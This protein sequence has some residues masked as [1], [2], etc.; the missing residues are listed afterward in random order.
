ML[1]RGYTAIRGIIFIATIRDDSHPEGLGIKVLRSVPSGDPGEY[2]KYLRDT[3]EWLNGLLDDFHKNGDSNKGKHENSES[4]WFVVGHAPPDDPTIHYTYTI[5]LDYEVFCVDSYPMFS[6]VNLPPDDVFVKSIACSPYG[7][8]SV[9]P[10][11][12]E[13]Y[14]YDWSSPPPSVKSAILDRYKSADPKIQGV[15]QMLGIPETLSEVEMARKG[16]YQTLVGSLLALKTVSKMLY[17]LEKIED[18]SQY[19][20]D[21]FYEHFAR[22]LLGIT[23]RPMFFLGDG[24]SGYL[25]S[26]RKK[27]YSNAK[28][29][30]VK[31]RNI[32]PNADVWVIEEEVARKNGED[33]PD[34]ISFFPEPG[35]PASKP[36]WLRPG[37][38]VQLATH[39]TDEANLQAGVVSI[40]EEILGNPVAKTHPG[41]Y[42]GV[43]CSFFHCVI[44]A[45]DTTAGSSSELAHTPAL[46]LLPSL[47]ET[48]LE[49]VGLT[50]LSRL[51]CY[52]GLVIPLLRSSGPTTPPTRTQASNGA[53]TSTGFDLPLDAWA[54][55]SGYTHD[56][57]TLVHLSHVSR[58]CREAANMALRWPRVNR[59][60]VI[61]DASEDLAKKLKA[62]PGPKRRYPF[63]TFGVEEEEEEEPTEKPCFGYFMVESYPEDEESAVSKRYLMKLKGVNPLGWEDEFCDVKE[64]RAGRSDLTADLEGIGGADIWRLAEPT[65]DLSLYWGVKEIK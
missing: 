63:V 44:V 8:R 47:S 39:L 23:L 61:G 58:T 26:Y 9:D 40:Q 51:G 4:D 20:Q 42:F 34:R 50:A 46:Q 10:D 11:T 32:K 6:L 14:R 24:Q 27:R 5:D 60:K 35:R 37:L 28:G 64:G 7:H 18:S 52:V 65:L 1:R 13:E 57:K 25:D 22:I 3:R 54:L 55:I 19:H 31:S 56:V 49:T 33:A 16:V 12:P 48:S 38:C 43:L 62:T 29:R 45:V 21:S 30:Y 2:A 15:H 17:E 59:F 53:S 36:M 41:V